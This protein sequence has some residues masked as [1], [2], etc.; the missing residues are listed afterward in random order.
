MPG[1]KLKISSSVDVYPS[2]PF[3]SMIKGSPVVKGTPP[4]I[5]IS[6]WALSNSKQALFVTMGSTFIWGLTVTT[7]VKGSPGQI[8]EF[9]ITV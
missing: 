9:G 7:I 2:G 8:S 4:V 5:V 6:I 1:S 3:H